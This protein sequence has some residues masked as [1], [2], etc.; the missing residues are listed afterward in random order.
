[1][2]PGGAGV[3]DQDVQA[4]EDAECFRGEVRSGGLGAEVAGDEGG[5]GRRRVGRGAGG[6]DYFGAASEQA[7]GDGGADAA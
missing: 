4:A 3:V 7:L 6:D 1:V 5:L 2:G